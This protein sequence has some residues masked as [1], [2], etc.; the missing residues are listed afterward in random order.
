MNTSQKQ[1]ISLNKRTIFITG[2]SRGIGREIALRC[3]REG[4]NIV[5]AAKSDAP[6]P[7]L[8]G[9]IYTVA[10]EVAE[11]GGRALAIKLDV[12]D[13]EQV[14]KAMQQAAEHFGGIDVLVNNAGAIS[15]TPVEHTP[16]KKYDLMNQINARAV[17]VCSQAAL[18]FLKKSEAGGHILNL[19]PPLN[20]AEKWLKP[21]AAYTL[22]K[23]GMTI[24]TLGMA[25][26]FKRYGIAVNSLWPKT[27][28]STAALTQVGDNTLDARSRTPAVMADAARE[29]FV[30]ANQAL[31]GQTLI[32]EDL[33]RERGFEDFLQYA[34]DPEQADNQF[35][36]LFLD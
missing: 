36:D 26:E 4:A 24:L 1:E 33:L 22:S 27:T 25:A 18:P 7:K 5:I 2:A 9:T 32:D 3:A 20:L 14:Q 6:H 21:Y 30:T 17:F 11:A 29:I 34:V 23:Y 13:A 28:I 12:R 15:L 19:S 35:P 10:E 31:T 8:P 16:V